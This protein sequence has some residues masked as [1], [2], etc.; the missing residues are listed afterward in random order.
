MIQLI[1]LGKQVQTH[2]TFAWYD[3][4]HGRFI[5][6]N[7]KCVW[8]QWEDFEYDYRRDSS[9]YPIE[10]FKAYMEKFDEQKLVDVTLIEK[11]IKSFHSYVSGCKIYWG[12]DG[13]NVS[14]S[15]NNNPLKFCTHNEDMDTALHEAISLIPAKFTGDMLIDER[16]DIKLI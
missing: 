12:N 1:N 2:N 9:R 13:W 7:G 11:Q 8:Q 14:L 5:T 3:L 10:M 15:L 6:A 16:G 4:G